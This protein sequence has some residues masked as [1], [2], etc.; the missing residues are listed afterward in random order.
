MDAQTAAAY[1]R[2]AGRYAAGFEGLAPADLPY[3][4]LAATFF[5]AGET[6]ADIGCG[7]GRDAA[8]LQAQGYAVTAYDSSA[9]M[10]AEAHRLHPG[11]QLAQATLP[12][13]AEIPAGVRYRNILCSAVLMHLPAEQP[14]AAVFRL[15]ELLAPG[16]RL[17]LTYRYSRLD[18]TRE[19]DGRLFTSILPGR[20]ELMLGSAGLSVLLADSQPDGRRPGI[21]WQA[22]V[23]EK[24]AAALKRGLSRLQSVLVHDK[25]DA[26][27]K[28]T[29]LRAL[30]AISRAEAS[31]AVRGE[32]Q[33]FVPL[34]A[35]A[36]WWLR[37][38]KD[39]L[40]AFPRSPTQQHTHSRLS[41]RYA[42]APDGRVARQIER[43][44]QS[45]SLTVG[46]PLHN[47]LFPPAGAPPR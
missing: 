42:L 25:K 32:S 2:D 37:Y 23:A 38:V 31:Q 17:V 1:E 40:P 44:V 12:D 30:G 47:P 9:A 20:L 36:R 27:H 21:R 43:R 29:L 35:A 28:L 33:V 3:L 34:A 41:Y 16:G 19:S 6:V 13:L 15:A 7:S 14:L 39:R 18:T 8:W 10:L 11:L 24:A 5:R 22:V 45:G 4:A 26:A 46:R